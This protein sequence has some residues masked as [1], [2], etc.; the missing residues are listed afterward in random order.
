MSGRMLRGHG[1]VLLACI[2]MICFSLLCCFVPSRAL[3]IS[4][5]DIDSARQ[6]YQLWDGWYWK[7]TDSSY[8]AHSSTAG[9]GYNYKGLGRQCVGFVQLL[10]HETTGKNFHSWSSKTIGDAYSQGVTLQVGDIIYY[11][12][13]DKPDARN[14]AAMVYSV[15]SNGDATFIECWGNNNNKIARGGYNGRSGLRT[16]SAIANSS[17]YGTGSLYGKVGQIFRYGGFTP[18]HGHSWH[19]TSVTWYNDQYDTVA[20]ACDCGETKSQL[21]YHSYHWS[22]DMPIKSTCSKCGWEN[23]SYDVGKKGYFVRYDEIA[24][25]DEMKVW[26]SNSIGTIPANTVLHPTDIGLSIQGNWMGKVTY[27]GVTG[28]VWLHDLYPNDTGGVHAYV[29][30]VCPDDGVPQVATEPGTYKL[31]C[32]DFSYVG[33]PDSEKKRVHKKGETVTVTKVEVSSF[34]CLWGQLS[35]G[36]IISMEHLDYHPASSDWLNGAVTTSV[37][38]GIYNIISVSQPSTCLDVAYGSTDSG[39]NVQAH[40][41]NGADAQ[42]FELRANPD[43]TYAISFNQTDMLLDVWDCDSADGTNV[44][45]HGSNGGANQKWYIERT[46]DGYYSFRSVANNKYLTVVPSGTGDANIAIYSG[47]KSSDQ[48]FSLKM[49]RTTIDPNVD[50]PMTAEGIKASYAYTG[51]ALTPKPS[52]VSL[53]GDISSLRVPE[54]GTWNTQYAFTSSIYLEAGET[55]RIEGSVTKLTGATSKATFLVYDWQTESPDVCYGADVEYDKPFS[56]TLTPSTYSQLLFY[57]GQP[58]STWG[59]AVQ[60]N[61]VKVYKVLKEGTDYDLTYRNNTDPG[62]ARVVVAGKGKYAGQSK[63]LTFEI[64]G[65]DKSYSVAFN[66]N[67]GTAVKTQTVKGGA[68]ASKPSN[69]TKMGCTFKGWFSDKGLT[70]AYDFNSVVKG[71]LTLYA[72]WETN[73]YKVSFQSNGGTAVKAQ[74]VKYGAK[75]AKPGDPSRA[76]YAFRGWFSDKG[77]T[78]TYDFSSA[79]KGDLTLYAKWQQEAPTS[80][81]DVPSGEWYATWVSQA[82][83]RGLMTGLKDDAGNYT[84]YFDPESPVTRA[85]VATVLWRIAGSPSCSGGVL[86]DVRGHWAQEAV[87]WCVSKGVVT[88]YTDGPNAGCFLP[89]NQVTREE[90]ATMVYRFAK[91]AG[92]KVSNPPKG[93]FNAASDTGAVSSWARDAMVWCSASGVLTGFAGGDR[94]LLLP[95]GTATRAQAA[96]IFTQMDRLAGGE[97]APYSEEETDAPVAADG[98]QGDAAEQPGQGPQL[99]RGETESGLCYAVVPDMAAGSGD[100]AGQFVVDQWYEDLAGRY[101]GPGV[102]VTSYKGEAAELTL[103]AQIDG[104]DVVSANLSWKGDDEAGAPDPEGRTRLT[105]LTV[106]RGCGLVSLDASGNRLEQV[107]LSGDEALGG[108]GA[109]RFLDLSGNPLSSFEPSLAPAL[110]S[111]ALSNCPLGAECLVGLSA[112]RGATGLAADLAGCAA[113]DEQAPDS[114]DADAA[115]PGEP[116]SDAPE[117]TPADPAEPGDGAD[118]PAQGDAPAGSDGSDIP[119]EPDPS[120]G[121]DQDVQPEPPAGGDSADGPLDSPEAGADRAPADSPAAEEPSQADNTQLEAAFDDE[122]S[123]VVLA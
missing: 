24:I 41:I 64:L 17:L 15:A 113:K 109:L 40:E 73:S 28:W 14:H 101:V 58:G 112:W 108:L 114:S 110:E 87:A 92:V 38:E 50:G 32:D 121:N 4:T 46:S 75:A 72:K 9:S 67:G 59:C 47:T 30:G 54:S 8:I 69:P 102:Y 27:K 99:T 18:V 55:Y 88:G 118:D 53:R 34:G 93:S 98:R 105:G 2:T 80:F 123:G 71:N 117:T 77:L 16:L 3:A 122:A 63:T 86:W 23:V 33:N 7:G 31:V 95:Q 89:D 111:L 39:T 66:S 82:A 42:K 61:D 26:G 11:Q 81:K 76:G 36:S 83:Q 90:L 52:V 13:G 20:L 43:G 97:A 74:A 45:I 62:K 70:K 120:D 19:T 60:W 119:V 10:S 12:D 48:K 21:E 79:V 78:K 85:Q 1:I 91:W 25:R 106:E 100:N 29:N 115:A 5:S 57:A 94:P 56:V 103:P 107:G 116:G 35:D 104:V 68:K 51:N 22:G 49:W 37:S 96:K 44:A 65:P 6:K 84:G